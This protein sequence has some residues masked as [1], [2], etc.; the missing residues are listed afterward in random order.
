VRPVPLNSLKDGIDKTR[1][2]G[3]AKPDTLFD[4]TNCWVTVSLSARPRPGTVID[5]VLP[6]GTVGLTT[7]RGK[8]VVFAD[9]EVDLTG[10]DQYE[11]EILTY[12]ELNPDG[13]SLLKIHFAEPFLGVL[14]VVAEWSDGRVV[15]YWLREP[16]T[17][18]ADT[19]YKFGDLVQPSTPN[20]FVYEATRLNPADPIWT[21][22]SQVVVGDFREPTTPN[23]FTYEVIDTIGTNPRTGTVEPIWPETDGATINEDA[24]SDQST[25]P[26]GGSGSST[27]PPQSIQ[28]RYGIGPNAPTSGRQVE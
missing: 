12:P 21:P 6:T 18:Q 9:H 3:W 15:H 11:L 1:V 24:D 26:A 5:A 14:Y 22:N 10:F 2:K 20:G 27:T 8:L 7:F 25:P 17:W 19:I 28:D 16:T 23:S 13:A 4:A